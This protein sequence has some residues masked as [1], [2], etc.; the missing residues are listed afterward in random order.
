[1]SSERFVKRKTM[2]LEMG[3]VLGEEVCYFKFERSTSRLV[4]S[5]VWRADV[6]K[7]LGRECFL[8]NQRY[9]T[10]SSSSPTSPPGT[11][12]RP[13]ELRRLCSIIASTF[14]VLSLARIAK[15]VTKSSGMID[16][17]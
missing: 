13:K 11:N 5:S 7:H 9:V 1:M 16:R 3:R 17:L 2:M 4:V 6:T 12:M 15:S 10:L 8:K 14:F